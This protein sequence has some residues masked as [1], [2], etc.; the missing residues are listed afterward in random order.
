MHKAGRK[1]KGFI[2]CPVGGDGWGAITLREDENAEKEWL[3]WEGLSPAR[4]ALRTPQHGEN[5]EHR[6]PQSDVRG[7][8]TCKQPWRCND[9]EGATNTLGGGLTTSPTAHGPRAVG[10]PWVGPSG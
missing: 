7:G 4:K 2:R 10:E 1:R 8:V 9:R 5:K 6:G 3:P